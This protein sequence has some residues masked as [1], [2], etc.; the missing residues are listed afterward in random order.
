MELNGLKQTLEEAN[1]SHLVQFWQELSD[2]EKSRL[3]DDLASIDFKQVNA[4][5]IRSQG[6]EL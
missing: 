6:R 2:D 3:N 4:N 5:F 1:Q